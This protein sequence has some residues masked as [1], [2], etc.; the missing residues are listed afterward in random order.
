MTDVTKIVFNN[1]RL[2]GLLVSNSMHRQNEN[3]NECYKINIFFAVNTMRK[4][5]KKTL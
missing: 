5:R 1:V 4:S 2:K 3:E